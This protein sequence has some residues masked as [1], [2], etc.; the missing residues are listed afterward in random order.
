MNINLSFVSI[1]F[2]VFVIIFLLILLKREKVSIKY[3]LVWFVLF[4]VL[5]IS[6]LIPGFMNF[7]TKILG[8]Q[9]ASNM[10]LS[11]FISV[12]VVINISLTVIVSSH[13]KKIRLLI[14]EISLLKGENKDDK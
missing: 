7:I 5:F 12:L 2:C 11:L 6:L 3:S 10:L 13:D 8:F 14:Q 9:M 1:V 4:L